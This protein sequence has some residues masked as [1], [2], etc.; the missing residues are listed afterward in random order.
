M[1]YTLWEDGKSMTD[2]LSA[3]FCDEKES[4]NHPHGLLCR[5]L[6]RHTALR[7]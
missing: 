3:F 7:V 5:R 1:L 2:I 4:V 6:L